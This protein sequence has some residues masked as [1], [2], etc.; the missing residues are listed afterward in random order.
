MT[1]NFLGVVVLVSL[2][3]HLAPGEVVKKEATHVKSV[4]GADT[5]LQC[6]VEH[7]PGV[8]YRAVRWYKVQAAPAPRLNGLLTRD[9]SNCTT[10]RYRGVER[11][12]QLKGESLSLFLPN[13]TC[14]DGG[15]YECHLVAHVGEQNREGRVLLTVTDCPEKVAQQPVTDTY[16]VVLAS[17]VLMLALLIFL[18]SYGSL[19]NILKD[20]RGA[21]K[22]QVV[23]DAPLQSLHKKDLMSIYTLGPKTSTVKHVC[24]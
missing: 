15:M 19:K 24:V 4:T 14:N 9:L 10:R 18:I 3:V 13:I 2:C 21:M 1:A 17:A 11:E 20:K 22:T 23:L 16:L 5:S 6:T 12:V 8:R 7:K